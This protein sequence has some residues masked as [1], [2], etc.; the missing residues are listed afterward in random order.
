M[1]LDR[2]IVIADQLEHSLATINAHRLPQEFQFLVLAYPNFQFG[3][4][5]IIDASRVGLGA[6]LMKDHCKGFQPI[7]FANQ[8]NSRA[9]LNYKI[10][11]LEFCAV[12][13]AIKLFRTYVYGR[14]SCNYR[15]RS[16]VVA[17]DFKESNWKIASMGDIF[18]RV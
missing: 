6:V 10:T 5:L 17:H 4:T 11:D 18:A 9:V 13:W 8:V 3:F 1:S 2:V 14:R 12:A 7:A 16:R 15:A